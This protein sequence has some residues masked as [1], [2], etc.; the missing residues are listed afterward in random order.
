MKNVLLISLFTSATGPLLGLANPASTNCINMGGRLI[1]G[2]GSTYICTF[3]NGNNCEEWKLFRAVQE[4]A[5]NY[6]CSSQ[7]Q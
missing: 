7:S 4:F 2:E 5:K 6:T 1:K 3:P